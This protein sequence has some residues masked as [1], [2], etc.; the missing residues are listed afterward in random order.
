VHRRPYDPIEPNAFGRLDVGDGNEV[1]WE[2]CGN[3]NGKVAVVLHGGPGA[4]CSPDH[5]RLFDPRVYK[6]V[7]FDQRNC[8]RSRPH[9]S[10]PLVSLQSNTTWHLVRDIELLRT[11]LGI[12]RWLVLGGSWGSALALAY[13]ERHPDRVSE[14]V[15]R[16]IF[17]LRPSE[18]Q[19]F[20]QGGA[21]MLFPDL[22]Q[23][24]LDP[25]PLEQR[26]DLISAYHQL[27]EHP[28]E[29]VR[30]PAAQAWSVWEASTVSLIP[31]NEVVA[32]YS[33]PGYAVAFA[34]IENHY[35]R[36]GGFFRDDQLIRDATRIRDIPGVIVQ[37]RYDICTPMATAWALHEAWPEAEFHVVPDAGHAY[38]EPG[39][40]HRLIEATDRFRD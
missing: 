20:Y 17:T 39:I 25:V 30:V 37:G 31:R 9:A 15:L 35:F 33:D 2:V 6:V 3:P 24:F 16:G 18:L 34:R 5:R 29:A 14:L 22:W 4:G 21:S 19:W 12:D 13:A 38:F 36:N 11:H 1:Y 23:R 27:L 32:S 7:L 8:G 10:D 28:D 26:S 40:L